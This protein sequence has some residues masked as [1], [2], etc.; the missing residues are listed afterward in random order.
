MKVFWSDRLQIIRIREE[1]EDFLYRTLQP[2]LRMEMMHCASN[3]I[4]SH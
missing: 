1:R 4:V 2:L 3:P